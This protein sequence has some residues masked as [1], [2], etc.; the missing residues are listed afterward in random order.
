MAFLPLLHADAY[1]LL[2]FDCNAN[3]A[4]ATVNQCRGVEISILKWNRWRGI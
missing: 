3:G 4:M 1:T 2:S